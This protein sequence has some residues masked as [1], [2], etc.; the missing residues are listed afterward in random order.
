[1]SGSSFTVAISIRS[2]TLFSR[3]RFSVCLIEGPPCR[4]GI[5]AEVFTRDELVLI[6]PPDFEFGYLSRD[7]LR[8]SN[9]LM[10]EQGS[11]SRRVVEAALKKAGIKLKCF[12]SFMDLDST[13][14]IKSAVQ[15][16]LGIGLVLRWAIFKELELRYS[17][18]SRPK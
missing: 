12:K 10:R 14:A 9:L 13:E 6:T 3:T 2:L 17:R 8:A 1:M 15:A 4:R 16:G 18:C 5:R 7:Q 11:G